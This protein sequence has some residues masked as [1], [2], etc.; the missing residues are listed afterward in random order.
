MAKKIRKPGNE[1]ITKLTDL[2][3][4]RL[5]AARAP[6]LIADGAAAGGVGGLTFALSA[7]GTA[8][9]RLRYRHA[10][11][12]RVLTLGRYPDLSIADARERARRERA[13]IQEGI[14]V[15]AERHAKLR[16]AKMA[17]TVHEIA[18]DYMAKRFADL[19][20]STIKQRSHHIEK[21]I[22]PKIGS[23][24]VQ[25]V[26]PQDIVHLLETLSEK[27]TANV[28]EVT[29]TTLNEIFKHAQARRA[30]AVNPC[31][32]IRASAITGKPPAPRQRLKLT[33]DELRAVLAALPSIGDW[34]ALAVKILLA[35][36]VRINELAKAEW[37]DVDLNAGLW[38]I[39]DEASK[40]RRGFTVPLVPTVVAWF[41]ELEVLACGSRFVLPART[42]QRAKS[43]GG[44]WH[45]EQRAVNAMLHKLCDQLGAKVRR[46]TPHDLR[47]TARSYLSDF[48]VAPIVAERCL[49]HKL[50][51]LLAIYDQHDYLEERRAA[52][53]T[54]TRFLQAC[55]TGQEWRRD[56]N[57]IPIHGA[58]NAA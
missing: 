13:R 49:N 12:P 1:A 25:S 10:G 2:E 26:R 36:C 4:R 47:S 32:G 27:K 18:E 51:G 24:P 16:D 5:I 20:V 46:F 11:K 44:D 31:F 6:V 9:W 7:S 34:N 58:R 50:A 8:A 42:R 57:V 21:L 19:S 3:I 52:L 55:E 30:V 33:Q 37:K 45:F 17:K 28:V 56:E 54:W 35:T 14:D 15:A 40:T 41:R 38:T 39:T 43:Y 23:M 53:T 48:G 22:L 29:A